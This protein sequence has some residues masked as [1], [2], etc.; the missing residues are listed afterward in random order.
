M[1]RRVSRSAHFCSYLTEELFVRCHQMA[2]RSHLYWQM[3]RLD[4]LWTSATKQTMPFWGR[5]SY[6]RNGEYGVFFMSVSW[7]WNF[8][9][10]RINQKVWAKR[11][12]RVRHPQTT[13]PTRRRLVVN[14]SAS[15]TTNCHYEPVQTSTLAR[16]RRWWRRLEMTTRVSSRFFFTIKPEGGPKDLT[17]NRKSY[18]RVRQGLH[19]RWQIR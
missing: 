12:Q 19:P 7:N 10:I 15:L 4:P 13:H 2:P 16:C 14:F 8:S 17:V 5:E 18:N 9:V 6:S 3:I 11:D 1:S